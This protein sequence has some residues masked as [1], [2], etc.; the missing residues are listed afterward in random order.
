MTVELRF[1]LA[2]HETKPGMS[3]FIPIQGVSVKHLLRS[4]HQRGGKG[5]ETRSK[6]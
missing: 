4:Q 1:I 2:A 6:G 5:Y 3:L